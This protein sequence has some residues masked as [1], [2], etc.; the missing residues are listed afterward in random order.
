LWKFIA[1]DKVK[2]I[3]KNSKKLLLPLGEGWDEGIKSIIYNPH[4]SPLPEGEGI[5]RGYTNLN[6]FS[7]LPSP[8]GE[9]QSAGSKRHLGRLS[10]G[11]FLLAKQ[12]KVSRLRVREP[13]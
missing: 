10:F 3:S 12:K 6:K 8:K 1:G 11:H 13:D 5:F 9:G 2:G 4:P 7:L